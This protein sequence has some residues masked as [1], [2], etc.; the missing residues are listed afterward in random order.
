MKINFW[1]C[2]Y[3]DAEEWYD[4]NDNYWSYECKHPNGNG[5][6]KLDNKWCSD[7]EDCKLLDKE[8]K[9]EK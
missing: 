5:W 2:E 9:N 6:C 3:H 8:I 1:D 4:D 7:K